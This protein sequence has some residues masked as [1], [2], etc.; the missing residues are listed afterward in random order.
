MR[1]YR[2]LTILFILSGLFSNT[3]AEGVCTWVFWDNEKQVSNIQFDTWEPAAFNTQDDCSKIQRDVWL[4]RIEIYEKECGSNVPPQCKTYPQGTS[5]YKDNCTRIAC[6][7]GGTLTAIFP[8][9]IVHSTDKN[10]FRSSGLNCL[11]DTIDPR[12][13]KH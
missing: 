11:P 4:S 1:V 10:Y 13:S 5:S 8:N 9:T 6:K 7:K 3:N 2:T 12:S